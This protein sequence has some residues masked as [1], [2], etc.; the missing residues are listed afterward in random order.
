MVVFIEGVDT[1]SACTTVA[2]PNRSI[3]PVTVDPA[4]QW[5]ITRAFVAI[6]YC[7]G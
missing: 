3:S 7:T 1:T 2:F 5:R 6:G 4:S